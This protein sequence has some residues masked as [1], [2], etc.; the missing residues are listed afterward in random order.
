MDAS[1]ILV[2]ATGT[3]TGGGSGFQEMV[4]YTRTDPPVLNAKIVRV[5]S[6]HLAG[7]VFQKATKLGIPFE[8]WPGPF[9]AEEYRARFK[10]SG[11][12]IV[13]C[14]GW[15]RIVH[16]LNPATTINIY[17]GPFPE[18]RGMFGHHVHE[19]VI[20][21]YKAGK[22]K[23][24]AVI[25]HYVTPRVDEG[26]M[27]AR[28]PVYIRDNDT[29]DTLG[30]RVNEKERVIQSIVLNLI[31]GLHISLDDSDM[32]HYDSLARTVLTMMRGMPR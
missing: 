21:L 10:L 25:M 4:E 27:I 17:P 23:Q 14:S 9:T 1:N 16:G 28:F 22:I 29:A 15:L 18:T 11:A 5:I 30:I 31:A 24:S 7:G 20:R 13:M 2:L 26:P 19:E 8:Y 6:N 3:K 12:D 32:V